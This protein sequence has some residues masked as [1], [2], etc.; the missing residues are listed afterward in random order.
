VEIAHDYITFCTGITLPDDKALLVF[1]D[2]LVA[3]EFESD[4][5]ALTIL[6]EAQILKKNLP[7]SSFTF[8]YMDGQTNM[9]RRPIHHATTL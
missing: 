3:Q 5:A 4:Q 2:S 9:C 6:R 1:L 7:V 8:N